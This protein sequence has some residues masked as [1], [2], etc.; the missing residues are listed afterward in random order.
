M[1]FPRGVSADRVVR[2]LEKNGYEVVRQKGSHVRLRFQG[3]PTH[4]VSVPNHPELKT[5]TLH[6]ILSAVAEARGVP[7]D[8]LTKML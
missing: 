3:T 6:A 1:K 2:V 5:G 8:V 4:S 7:L